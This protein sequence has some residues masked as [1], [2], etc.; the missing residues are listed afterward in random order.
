LG[1]SVAEPWVRDNG[2]TESWQGRHEIL[3]IGA[4]ELGTLHS[5]AVPGQR[6]QAGCRG[7]GSRINTICGR[8]SFDQ[9]NLWV[10]VNELAPDANRAIVYPV[11]FT[12]DTR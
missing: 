3:G 1:W 8:V 5:N 2:N 12:G 7:L 10:Q 6:L 9:C 4:L 11:S